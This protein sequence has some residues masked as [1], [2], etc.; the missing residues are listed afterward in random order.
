MFIRYMIRRRNENCSYNYRYE[1]REQY[2]V[3]FGFS[4]DGGKEKKT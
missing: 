1:Y 4:N 2:H 3:R